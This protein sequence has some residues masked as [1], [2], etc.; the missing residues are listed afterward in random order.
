MRTASR[1]VGKDHTRCTFSPDHMQVKTVWGSKAYRLSKGAVFFRLAYEW[2]IITDTIDWYGRISEELGYS[3]TDFPVTLQEWQ[4][5][6]H[7]DEYN[8][9]KRKMQYHLKAQE[10][11]L[12]EYRVR[13]KNGDYVYVLDTGTAL[14]NDY[15]TP[16]K[17]TGVMH[18]SHQSFSKQQSMEVFT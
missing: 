8:L 9:I 4:N 14:R 1:N 17:F 5:I 11:Y 3:E 2:D 18:L 16:Y 7:P 10:Q 13:R 15:D 12:V 6:I